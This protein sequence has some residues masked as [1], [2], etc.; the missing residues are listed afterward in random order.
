MFIDIKIY[1]EPALVYKITFMNII[2]IIDSKAS[3][4]QDI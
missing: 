2:K 3:F 1:F 4:N